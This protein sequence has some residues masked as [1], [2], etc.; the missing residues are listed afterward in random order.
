MK[1]IEE[2][3][4]IYWKQLNDNKSLELYIK[5]YYIIKNNLSRLQSNPGYF[6]ENPIRVPRNQIFLRK[7]FF[8]FSKLFLKI[9]HLRGLVAATEEYFG[10]NSRLRELD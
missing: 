2:L 10:W 6:I 1:T 4:P 8:N 9:F 3:D 5:S 7:H